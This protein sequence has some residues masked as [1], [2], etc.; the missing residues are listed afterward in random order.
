VRTAEGMR[1]NPSSEAYGKMDL[2]TVLMH[3]LGHAIGYQHDASVPG[4]TR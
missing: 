1:A 3:E 2:L 4:A